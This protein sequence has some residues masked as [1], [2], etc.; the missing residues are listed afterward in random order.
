MIKDS[1]T[2]ARKLIECCHG[3]CFCAYEFLLWI[4]GDDE[5]LFYFYIKTAK[6]KGYPIEEI[7]TYDEMFSEKWMQVVCK[8]IEA[9]VNAIAP[10]FT[11]GEFYYE[12]EV[13]RR[14]EIKKKNLNIK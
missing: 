8:F 2:C 14:D 9:Y 11:Y 5:E 13:A 6:T 1:R 12:L 3:T 7:Y 10:Q 4:S